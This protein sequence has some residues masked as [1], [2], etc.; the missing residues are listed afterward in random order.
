MRSTTQA[1][2]PTLAHTHNVTMIHADRFI[3]LRFTSH[4]S[5]SGHDSVA[6]L[7]YLAAAAWCVTAG[8]GD[9]GHVPLSDGQS[10]PW[11]A[12]CQT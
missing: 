11:E 12:S 7:I 3:S 8:H 6:H 10:S 1:P 2:G 5:D 4:M 9:S